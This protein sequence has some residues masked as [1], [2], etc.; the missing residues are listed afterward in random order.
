MASFW[1]S[2]QLYLLAILVV[3]RTTS[4]DCAAA[5]RC[6]VIVVV[7]DIAHGEVERLAVE[8]EFQLLACRE[9]VVVGRLVGENVAI[10][11]PAVEDISECWC[12]T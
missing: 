11:A 12:H 6:G 7:N 5:G 2:C 4:P 10:Y 9:I 3:T 1:F 8:E